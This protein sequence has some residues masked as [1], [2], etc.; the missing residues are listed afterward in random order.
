[1]PAACYYANNFEA[2]KAVVASLDPD[3]AASMELVAD[4]MSSRQL[5]DEFEFILVNFSTTPSVLE[6]LQEQDLV[7]TEALRLYTQTVKS[8][9]NHPNLKEKMAAI[10]RRNTALPRISVIYCVRLLQTNP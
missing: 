10:I 8:V 9:D 7:A 5:R 4:L 2:V 6:R 3:D 1:M